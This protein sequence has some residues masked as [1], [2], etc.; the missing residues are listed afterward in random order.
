MLRAYDY[1]DPQEKKEMHDAV[2]FRR[3]KQIAQ[4]FVIEHTIDQGK[5]KCPICC[6]KQTKYIF[7]RWDVNYRFCD[8]CQSI[9][10]P[11]DDDILQKYLQLD[12]MKKLRT[13]EEYQTQADERRIDIWTDLVMWS[14]YRIFRYLGKK[15]GLR[16]ID[17]GNRYRTCAE[18]FQ[19][20]KVIDR[21]ELRDSILPVNTAHLEEADV[22]LYLNQLQHENDPIASLEE[23]GHYLT[24]DG[25][26]IL[27]TRV[28]SGFDILTLKGGTEDIFPYE[29][30]M[31]PSKKGLAII[32]EK[33]G[34]EL[35]EIT[36]P[37]TRD[38]EIVMKNKERIEESNFFIKY[39]IDT[40]DRTT[41]VDFQQFLQKSGLSSFAQVIARKRS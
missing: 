19:N 37:G 28:G 17:Y 2:L 14:E 29:H 15:G 3:E 13:S 38:M 4:N 18:L 1:A 8:N 27:N 7:E 5:V 30:I 12:E 6:S 33:A 11:M 34:Y 10:V 20:S 9:Y 24:E 31:L 26:L 41:I 25:L 21:Y 16:V 36:T 40:A 22:I 35:L 23:I 39:L 32:L